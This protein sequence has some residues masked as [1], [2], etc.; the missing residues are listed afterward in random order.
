MKFLKSKLYI[1]K[2]WYRDIFLYP[3]YKL[4]IDDI[5]DYDSYWEKKRGEDIGYLSDWQKRRADII[6]N[7]IKADDKISFGDI[8]CGDGSILKYLGGKLKVSESI[9]Y[10]SSEF[11]LQKAKS[12]GINGISI[13]LNKTDE[14]KKI[15]ESD[16]ILMLEVLE[17]I[18]ES[19]KLLQ[20]AFNKSRRGVFFSFPNTGFFTYR[21][22]LLFGKFPKQWQVFPKEHLRFW[23][24]RDLIW[25]L[26]ALD[27][28]NYKINY[29]K[30]MPVLNKI[31]PSL[32]A[33]AF[34]VEIKK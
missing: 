2:V 14:F 15:K 7:S 21:L 5:E 3:V 18:P 9:G 1:L 10:D 13:D 6:L 26:K 22:R 8:G 20:A 30:G 33:A 28:N 32:F 12:E 31:F 4:N 29:Y 19:E 24:A 23:T 25:W 34:L 27:Y 17:H 11:A 16:F